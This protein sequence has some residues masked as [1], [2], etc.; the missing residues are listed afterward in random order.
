MAEDPRNLPSPGAD[1]EDD[2]L[3]K[4]DKLL[5]RHRS[6]TAESGGGPVPEL[7]DSLRGNDA[8]VPGSIPTLVDM[9]SGPS[10]APSVSQRPYAT[11]TANAGAVFEAG[12]NLRLAVKLES[13]RARLLER[14]G[15][16]P[17]RA[18]ALDQ[19]ITE[20]KRSLPAIVRSVFSDGP[21]RE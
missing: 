1:E 7:T 10:R 18:Q 4:L 14:I 20:L 19:L 9:V 17:V 5:H 21:S 3:G 11:P 8:S 2:V 13:E 16:D 6:G 12:I 15:N